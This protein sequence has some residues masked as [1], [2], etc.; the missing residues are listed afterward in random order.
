M[1]NRNDMELVTIWSDGAE[2]F[3][4]VAEFVRRWHTSE[5]IPGSLVRL[6]GREDFIKPDEAAEQMRQ[7]GIAGLAAPPVLPRPSKLISCP[8]C[9]RSLSPMAVTCPHCGHPIPPP[10]PTK[11]QT[12]ENRVCAVVSLVMP[13][14]GQLIQGRMVP[15]AAFFLIAVVLWL[16][17]LGWIVHI[18]AAVDAAGWRPRP[19]Q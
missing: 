14:L 12:S 11:N 5:L 10:P 8:A 17:F 18:V 2:E 13:G 4:P 9:D 16:F 15:A 19:G 1:R 7:M 6:E 3:I